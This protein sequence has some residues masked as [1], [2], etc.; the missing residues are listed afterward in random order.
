MKITKEAYTTAEHMA[1]CIV[2]HHLS[3]GRDSLIAYIEKLLIELE[4][5]K[6]LNRELRDKERGY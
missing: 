2:D 5:A 6:G 3:K 4:V 1:A